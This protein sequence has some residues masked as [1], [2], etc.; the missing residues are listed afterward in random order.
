MGNIKNKLDR[1]YIDMMKFSKEL[2]VKVDQV[3]ENPDDM[4]QEKKVKLLG[5]L[6]ENLIRNLE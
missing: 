4:P 6:S 1:V 5:S 3:L 2:D